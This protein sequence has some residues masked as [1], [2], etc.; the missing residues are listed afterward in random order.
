VQHIDET[1]AL[2]GQQ[3]VNKRLDG[4]LPAIQYSLFEEV[5]PVANDKKSFSRKKYN[6][7]EDV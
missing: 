1:G 7:K 4:E 2:L 5:A 3:E 6:K